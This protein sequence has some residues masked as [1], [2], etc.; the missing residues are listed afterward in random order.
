VTHEGE[1]KLLDF[2]I[3]K[4]LTAGDELFTQTIPALRDDAGIRQ[5]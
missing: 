5:P 3:A 1:L 4:V 2:G